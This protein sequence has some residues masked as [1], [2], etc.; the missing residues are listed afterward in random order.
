MR[1]VI[2]FAIPAHLNKAMDTT[3]VIQLAAVVLFAACF[4]HS[5]RTEGQRL[6]QQWFLIGYIFSILLISL[7]VVVGERGQIAYNPNMLVFGAAPSL[8]V[9]LFPALLYLAYAIAKR[10]VDADNLRGMAYMMFATLPWLLLPLDALALNAGWWF[11]PSESVSFLN[12]IPFYL[13]F[14]WGITGAAFYLMVGRLRRIRF[15]GNGQFFA[16][17]IAA[18]LLAGIT[19]V[20]IALVQVLIDFLANLGGVT[21]LYVVLALLFL[22]LPLALFLNIPRLTKHNGRIV[23][24]R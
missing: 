8:T 1:Y 19:L 23:N 17:I 7:L 10:F 22:L 11:F 5:W 12:G 9:M 18:P 20:L 13:P 2:I 15:R 4:V 24:R 16:M 6:A 3:F 21:I 14:A